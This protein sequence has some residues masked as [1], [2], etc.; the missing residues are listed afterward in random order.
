M[1]PIWLAR[2]EQSLLTNQSSPASR[3]LQLAT[4]SQAFG[5]QNRTLVF[6][7]LQ[8]NDYGILMVT[9]R[10]SDK[11]AALQYTPQAEIAWYFADSREQFR[12]HGEVVINDVQHQPTI[13]TQV[14]QTLSTKAKLSFTDDIE[15]IPEN[16][17]VL[18]LIPHKVDYLCLAEV[19]QRFTYSRTQQ[20]REIT[21]AL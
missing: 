5:V 17:L 21:K 15:N 14:W 1:K 10:C 18:S 3:Y 2:L 16:F 7:G 9:D 6:R 12:L 19:H 4:Y 13:V 8:A 20:W 11:Y